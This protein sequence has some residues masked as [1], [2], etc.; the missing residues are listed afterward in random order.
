M[1][2][3]EVRQWTINTIIS[4]HKQKK[5]NFEH[6]SQRNIE[7]WS[8]EQEL[9]LIDSI[10]DGY[11]IPNI[12]FEED[13]NIY[14]IIDGN[15]RLN[16]IIKYFSDIEPCALNFSKDN[17]PKSC[18]WLADLYINEIDDKSYYVSYIT[19]E[20][21][22]LKTVCLHIFNIEYTAN[23]PKRVSNCQIEFVEHKNLEFKHPTYFQIKMVNECITLLSKAQKYDDYDFRTQINVFLTKVN[24]YKLNAH[25]ILLD[26]QELSQKNVFLSEIFYRLNHGTSLNK[27]ERINSICFDDPLWIMAQDFA[28]KMSNKCKQKIYG[29]KSITSDNFDNALLFSEYSANDRSDELLWANLFLSAYVS[30][31]ES[32]KKDRIVISY[33]EWDINSA[34]EGKRYKGKTNITAKEIDCSEEKV[35]STVH[36]K[37]K[38]SI[39]IAEL[40]SDCNP[41]KRHKYIQ[42]PLFLYCFYLVYKYDNPKERLST[43]CVKDRIPAAL[44]EID[45]IRDKAESTRFNSLLQYIGI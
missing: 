31:I 40:L 12:F 26:E 39:E 29:F 23:T 16:T 11:P 17:A 13:N 19:Q 35:L 14:T 24:S 6:P 27:G 41:S 36:S 2:C 34:R 10:L 9:F 28:R 37:I 18:S 20:N 4:D 32:S 25:R 45:K 43:K 1:D 8:K 21:N 33:K 15:Q 5:I 44:K 30:I 7:R 38:Q 3:T 42:V 22:D